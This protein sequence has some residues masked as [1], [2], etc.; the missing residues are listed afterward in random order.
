MTRRCGLTSA[1]LA[2][3]ALVLVGL[4]ACSTFHTRYFE[5][6]DNS[7][8]RLGRFCL[9]PR[10]FAFQSE[11]SFSSRV[12]KGVFTVT[13]RVQDAESAVGDYDWKAGQDAV[14]SL[15][16]KFYQKVTDEFV[17]E[18]LILYQIPG[19]RP[20]IVLKPDSVNF[21]PRREDFLTFRFGET[22]IAPVVEGL[23]VVLHVIRPG[24]P[25]VADSAVFMME[26]VEREDR[27]LLKFNEK[28][29][30]Y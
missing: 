5:R 17:P 11:T 27:G 21:S 23:R 2:L 4:C 26:R 29:K 6:L 10:I 20:P 22:E 30:G 12:V 19:S 3:S 25:P 15:A 14:D 18:S 7:E 13:M 28:V 24:L 9:A 8:V 16:E 1:L